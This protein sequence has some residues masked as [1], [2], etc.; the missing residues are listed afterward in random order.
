MATPSGGQTSSDDSGDVDPRWSLAN[1]RTL[2]AYTR[3]AIAFLVA[4]LAIIGSRPVV[5]TSLL[6]AALGLPLIAS[7]AWVAW[8]GRRRFLSAERAMRE[9]RP[10]DVP[11]TAAVIPLVVLVIAI[12]AILV[13][14][15]ELTRG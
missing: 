12:G 4:G 6:F 15:L 1:E 10:L 9:G 8:R 13:S 11:Q 5:D 2:L 3:T 14:V 7:S